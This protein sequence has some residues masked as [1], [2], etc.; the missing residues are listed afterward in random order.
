[1]I[2]ITTNSNKFRSKDGII[3]RIPDDDFNI[4]PRS[5]TKM[6]AYVSRATISK[7]RDNPRRTELHS[8]QFFQV[9]GISIYGNCFPV[10]DL[11]KIFRSFSTQSIHLN[12]SQP[13]GIFLM[14][15]FFITNK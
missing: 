3:I 1:M 15:I 13:R 6:S 8:L 14:G 7:A 11:Y 9:P 4:I 10:L 2:E 12:G 5:V